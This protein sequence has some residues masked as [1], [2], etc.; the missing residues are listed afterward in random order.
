M[1]QA[2]HQEDSV[3]ITVIPDLKISDTIP[4]FKDYFKKK[5]VSVLARK[6]AED[7]FKTKNY[8]PEQIIWIQRGINL[9]ILGLQGSIKTSGVGFSVTTLMEC[10][11]YAEE[12]AY[13]AGFAVGVA[14]S[15]ALDPSYAGMCTTAIT[16][17]GG[18]AGKW[19][20]LY[21]YQQMHAGF[22]QVNEAERLLPEP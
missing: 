8:T 3:D 2:R 16:T 12:H 19:C 6:V 11:G 1:S 7:I 13:W 22:D 15:L 18:L 21:A 10:L 14:L 4:L 9:A 5:T 20:T 17:A